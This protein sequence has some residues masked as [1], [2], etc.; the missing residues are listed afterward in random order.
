MDEVISSVKGTS[1]R[2]K[3]D[4]EALKNFLFLFSPFP[5]YKNSILSSS[6]YLT[7]SSIAGKR[8]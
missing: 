3:A 7:K 1:V 4:V 6:L 5:S 2:Q 8:L